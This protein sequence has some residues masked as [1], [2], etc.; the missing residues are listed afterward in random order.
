MDEEKL[1][2]AW[3]ENLLVAGLIIYALILL[4]LACDQLFELGLIRPELD[5]LLDRD[6]QSLSRVYQDAAVPKEQKEAMIENI[7]NWHE[8]SVPHL[9]DSLQS[10]NPAEQAAA[11]D[12]LLRI[13]VR[14]FKLPAYATRKGTDPSKWDAGQWEVW[15]KETKAL[16]DSRAT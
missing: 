16:L 10:G 2:G 1:K 7:V 8:F 12:C 11:R 5:R 3:K 13:G 15:W 6:I 9:L 4:V 14:F